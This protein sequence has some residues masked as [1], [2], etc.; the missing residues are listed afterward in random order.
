MQGLSGCGERAWQVRQ[1]GKF[2]R[3]KEAAEKGLNLD[4]QA[5][6]VTSGA[7]AHDDSIG[8]CAG[9]KSPAYR[10]NEFFRK[11][12]KPV[13]VIE[14]EVLGQILSVVVGDE[15]ATA[16]GGEETAELAQIAP[17]A[18]ARCSA[19]EADDTKAPG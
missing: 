4:E 13:P 11:P 2:C 12:V 3:A 16:V 15:L 18:L 5:E 1:S 6:K 10:P 9:D 17:I 19:A 14:V 8:F 7:E